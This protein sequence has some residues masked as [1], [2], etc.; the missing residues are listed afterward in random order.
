V[1]SWISCHSAI[2][3]G[4]SGSV[5]AARLPPAV[6][7]GQSQTTTAGHAGS[8][9]GARGLQVDVVALDHHGFDALSRQPV[10]DAAAATPP[11]MTSVSTISSG[12]APVSTGR[13]MSGGTKSVWPVHSGCSVASSAD[14]HRLGRRPGRE[15]AELAD[16][17]PA[18]ARHRCRAIAALAAAHADTA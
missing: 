10:S 5:S 8:G 12:S 1:S 15:Q 7:C 3:A 17:G 13:A 11:P 14:R 4:P 18:Q 2:E 6:H 16:F 9:V